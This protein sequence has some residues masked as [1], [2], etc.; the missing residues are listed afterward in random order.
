MWLELACKDYVNLAVVA[1]AYTRQDGSLELIFDTQDTYIL[2]GTDA[3][4]ARK[5]LALEAA[6]NKARL[7]SHAG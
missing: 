7:D 6:Q 3:A 1:R 4:A 5:A 2:R